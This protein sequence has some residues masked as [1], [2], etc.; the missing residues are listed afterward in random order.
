MNYR[1][2]RYILGFILVFESAFM[3]ISLITALIFFETTIFAWIIS[4]LLCLITGRL[5]IFKKPQN[6]TLYAKEGYVIVALSWIILSLFGCVPFI[7]TGSIPSFTNALFETV[8]GFTTTGATILDDVESL[9][10]SILMW[11]SFS[12]WIGGMG[13]LVFIMAFLPLSGGNNLHIMKAESTGPSVSKI[14]PR[15]KK[16]ALI[17][18]VIYFGLTII[19]FILLLFG[20][21]S[22]F[23]AL[24][25]AI[26]TAGT[27]GFGIKNDSLA[28]YSV[29]LQSVVTAFMLLFSINFGSYYLLFTGR[30]RE[31]FTCEFKAFIV[32]VLVATA[33]IT[34]NIYGMYDGLAESFR[35]SLFTVASIISTT[36][37]STVDFGTW[38]ELSK[39]IIVMAMIS[40]ACAGSTAGGIKVSRIVILIKGMLKEFHNIIHPNQVKKITIDK[41]TLE[42]EIVRSV[43]VYIICYIMIFIP[44]VLVVS[45]ENHD[46]VTNFTSVLTALNNVG[47]GLE[48]VG[49][50]SNFG[51]LSVP[52]KLVLIFDMLAGR[53]ELFPMMI[54]FNRETWK[55]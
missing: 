32:I 9:P 12:H 26:S 42:H 38:P 41:K 2:I 31:A 39:T 13:V 4:I 17:L 27:G 36:G 6:T 3:L 22:V 30:L 54:L 49:P 29:Y 14:V 1:M 33:G 48:K 20:G 5:L 18:Y 55:K 37:F 51:F 19:Q 21:M 23:D 53:L 25:T 8:S 24:N 45:L 40:G 47:P 35:N 7:V 50:T 44:S 28:S 43:S 15:I 46:M 52:T 11:R 34:A 16:T 10:K